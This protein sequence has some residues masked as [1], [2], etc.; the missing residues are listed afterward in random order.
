VAQ[1]LLPLLVILVL[2][3][4]SRAAS[5]EADAAL[6]PVFQ[7]ETDNRLGDAVA[8]CESIINSHPNAWW[9]RQILYEKGRL[10]LKLNDRPCAQQVIDRIRTFYPDSIEA[11]RV[12]ILLAQMAG[13]GLAEAEA[14][15]ARERDANELYAQAYQ[16]YKARQYETALQHAT[17]LVQQFPNT[18]AALRG[19]SQ[20][21]HLFIAL[22]RYLLRRLQAPPDQIRAAAQVILDHSPNSAHAAHVRMVLKAEA[23]NAQ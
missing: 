8:L 10:C 5:P 22:N 6:V 13:T 1:R 23:A 20:Q 18:P 15:Y 9:L 14:T 7:A 21:A 11:A 17:A 3:T 12:K 16:E 19:L 2:S 4:V